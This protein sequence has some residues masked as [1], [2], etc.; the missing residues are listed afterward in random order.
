MYL[1]D[2]KRCLEIELYPYV[3]KGA[4]WLDEYMPG[5]AKKIAPK[6]LDLSSG[7]YCICGQ[8]FTDYSKRPEGAT[9][10]EHMGFACPPDYEFSDCFNIVV[11]YD[12]GQRSVYLE[13]WV[14]E[15]IWST[16][17]ALWIDEVYWRVNP[18]MP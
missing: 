11:E 14:R 1:P 10:S 7:E 13:Q 2:L 9:D 8:L 16:L 5:W 6:E 12:G 18:V 4:A 17:D 15:S 3:Q